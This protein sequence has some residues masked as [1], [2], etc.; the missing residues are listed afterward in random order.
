MFML[1]TN[2]ERGVQNLKIWIETLYRQKLFDVTVNID[3]HSK[4]NF[5][6]TVFEDIEFLISL[7]VDDNFWREKIYILE[8][9]GKDWLET[10]RT[11]C[12]KAVLLVDKMRSLYTALEAFIRSEEENH[13]NRQKTHQAFKSF[14]ENF[15]NPFTTI[16]QLEAIMSTMALEVEG[17]SRINEIRVLCDDYINIMESIE[18]LVESNLVDE[19]Y[20][21]VRTVMN[22]MVDIISFKKQ[23]LR[24]MGI[25][26]A[27][28]GR[29][30]YNRMQ[31]YNTCMNHEKE[32]LTL[33]K[34][35][36][37]ILVQDLNEY[38]AKYSELTTLVSN[39]NFAI[40]KGDGKLVDMLDRLPEGEIKH[41]CS[42]IILR[43]ITAR[44]VGHDNFDCITMVTR[45]FR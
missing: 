32:L 5:D 34:N 24:N 36:L 28:T 21:K 7:V 27:F 29:P 15:H 16:S 38:C 8:S 17:G 26:T 40:I 11:T 37:K 44:T 1:C 6:G 4:I 18:N 10:L 2:L 25:S 39:V 31:Y 45:R 13:K 30:D 14:V 35:P 23:E 20:Q 12:S 22:Q 43:Q 33:R 42:D 3:L 41:K 19:K 9:A